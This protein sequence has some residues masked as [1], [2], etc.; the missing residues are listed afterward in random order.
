MLIERSH[1]K[2]KMGW[3][4]R[5]TLAKSIITTGISNNSLLKLAQAF[6][7]AYGEPPRRSS[8]EWMELYHRNPRLSVPIHQIASDVGAATYGIYRKDDIKKIKLP[9]TNIEKLLKKPNSDQT[10]TRYVLFYTTMCYLLLPVGEAYWIKERNGLNKVTELWPCPPH[11]VMSIPSRSDPYFN[12]FPQG[13]MQSTIIKVLPTDMVYFKVPNIENPYLRGIG[14]SEAIGDEAEIDE[15]MSK[16]QKRFFFNDAVPPMVGMMP[17]AGKE[18]VDRAEELWMQKYGG[19]N[20]TSK[21]AWLNFDAK[22]QTLRDTPKEMDFVAARQFLADATRQFFSIPPELFGDVK[23][24]NRSTIESSY[25]LYSKNILRKKLMFLTDTIN[26]QLMPEFGNDIYFEFDE[27]VP[28][29]KEFEL[30]KASEGLKNGG[31]TVDEW[32]RAN[33][34]EELPDGKGQILYTPLN[35]IPTSIN[36]DGALPTNLPPVA[37]EPPAK[38]AKTLTPEHKNRMWYIFDKAAI[39][40][41]RPFINAL[42]RYFQTQQDKIN[43]ALEKSIKAATDDPDELLDWDKEDVLLVTSLTPLWLAS[44]KEGYEAANSTFGF[45]I[46]FDVMNPK[47]LEWVREFGASQVKKINDTTKTKLQ[48][49][50]SEGIE[51][52]ESIPKLRDRVS[53]VMTEAKT[54]R[55]VKIAR[56][57][58]HNSTG[59]GTHE[60]FVAA[61]LKQKEWLTAIDGR[62]RESHAA[63]NG[64]VVEIDQLF[65]NGLGFPGDPSGSAEEVVNCRCV[66]LPVLPD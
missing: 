66:L 36:G 23:N 65:S 48:L 56:T 40:N 28:E 52:G 5:F 41:E 19:Y 49:T 22:F 10:I 9:N 8:H 14:D 15:Y 12:I 53:A 29:D 7:P 26:L 25:F 61:G 21:M 2:Q 27:C 59:M 60:T 31:I 46:S 51:V 33:G 55:A 37:P 63:I 18:E 47:F 57:E 16:W 24:S 32:R 39:K 6:T 20:N 13:N 43:K 44:L 35:M 30:K 42:K 45:G 64:E 34:W 11:W 3:R 4:D 58:T 54:S 1:I 50:L 62:E 17:G 38:S